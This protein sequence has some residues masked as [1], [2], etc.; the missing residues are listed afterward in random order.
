MVFQRIFLRATLFIMLL[1]INI[2]F[3]QPVQGPPDPG[4]PPDVP[5]DGGLLW[6]LIA[7]AGYGVKK[8]YDQRKKNRGV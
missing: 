2:G 6:L 7:G 3:A 1:S 5:L 4:G 8:I